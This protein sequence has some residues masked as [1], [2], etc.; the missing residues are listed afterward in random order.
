MKLNETQKVDTNLYELNITV[1]GE[2][3]AKALDAS[4]KKN[5]PSSIS[6]V[7]VRARL[8]RASFTRW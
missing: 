7:S 3:Y 4:F 2:Q 5:A 8:P 1:D 6:P